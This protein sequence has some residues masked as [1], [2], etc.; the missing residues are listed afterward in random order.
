MK[1]QT[2]ASFS[3]SPFDHAGAF[4]PDRRD[5]LLAPI[6]RTRDSD[7]L[8]ESNFEECLAALGG[9][10]EDVEVHRFG[11]WG[12]GWFEI[13]LIRPDSPAQRIAEDIADALANYPVINDED[14]S[15]REW[16]AYEEAWNNW[17][18][19]EF[20]DRVAD[21]FGLNDATE[22]FLRDLSADTL[23]EFYQDGV[24]NGDYYLSEGS[25]VSIR[26]KN[27]DCSRAELAQFIRQQRRILRALPFERYYRLLP[28]FGE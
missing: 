7:C 19:K 4:L 14:F 16:E 11:H 9:E 25:G 27:F 28:I 20:V 17:G 12:P 3:P 15:R 23:R 8:N 6:S 18:H 24:S 22:E 5:W 13:I 26:F 21:E 2:Y 10:S 1:L